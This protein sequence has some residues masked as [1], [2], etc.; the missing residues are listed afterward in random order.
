MPPNRRRHCGG[1]YADAVIV[2]AGA[3]AKARLRREV[4]AARRSRSP[5][6]RAAD[7]ESL[8]LHVLDLPELQEPTTAAAYASFGSEPGTGP[9]LA[10]LARRGSQV[11]LPVLLVDRDLDWT[12]PDDDVRLGVGAVAR[13]RVVV[14]PGLA[15]DPS[16]ARLGR[17]GGS[18]DRALARC[19][20]DTVRVL[21]LH[22]DELV[23]S[24][25]T[26]THDQR[27]HIVVTPSR[28]M[29]LR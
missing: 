6:Q 22:D 18:Y 27:V 28:I 29:R 1:A 21:L 9:L 25:P 19:G 8:A 16:G 13:A 26:A 10:G 11:L 17:G 12:G 2:N 24:V 7:A 15:A 23:E 3:E 4:L 14:C 20:A 5:E